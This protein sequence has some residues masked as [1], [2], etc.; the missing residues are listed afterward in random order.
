MNFLEN[1]RRLK[2][3]IKR[4]VLKEFFSCSLRKTESFGGIDHSLIH[5]WEKKLTRDS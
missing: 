3:Y 2:T 5:F 4:V 1:K